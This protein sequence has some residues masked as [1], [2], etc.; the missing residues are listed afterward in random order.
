MNAYEAQFAPYRERYLPQLEAWMQAQ[1]EPFSTTPELQ[2]MLTYHMGWTGPGAG[3]RARGKRIRPFLLLLVNQ[4]VGGP[5]EHA[6]P[7]AAAVEFVHNFSLLHDDIQDHSPTRRGRPTVW[8][9]WGIEQAINAGDALFALAFR[10]L[11]ALRAHHPA[12]VVLDVQRAL[13]DAC[14]ALTQG[15][16][17]DLAYE[18]RTDLT[19]ADY[20]PM[21]R[22]KTAAL[23]RAAAYMG[24]RLGHPDPEA[25]AAYAR[26]GE[27][28][29]LAF[30]IWD[31]YLGIWGDPAVTG[32][33]VASDLV[34]R[35]NTLP[36][37]YGLA[38]PESA[39]ARRW[40]AGAIHEDEAAAMA[41]A[42]AETGAQAFTQAQAQRWTEE[43][44]RALA[45]APA[46]D[47]EARAA[48]QALA[49]WL[50]RRAY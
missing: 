43:A 20:W 12:D 10:T 32:K 17:L 1:M 45:Q 3:P 28:L 31:D 36:V 13:A 11:D 22:G 40:R 48:L 35:K 25:A 29:G 47:P 16:H 8:A 18:A 50:L 34:A 44:L 23:L 4:A 24:A 15:Q 27:A 37:L 33:S 9:R 5:W 46:R 19:E 21:I 42:L 2:A 7:A 39:F 26:F 30:Q 41:Q 49:L 6:I 38:H 14:L